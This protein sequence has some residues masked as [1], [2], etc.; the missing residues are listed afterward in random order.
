MLRKLAQFFASAP[1][2]PNGIPAGIQ[3]H[4]DAGTGRDAA[5]QFFSRNMGI[6]PLVGGQT[7]AGGPVDILYAGLPGTVYLP[8][9]NAV[10]FDTVKN[11]TFWNHHRGA[12]E[13]AF[14]QIVMADFHHGEP[15]D[16]PARGTA[17]NGSSF[18]I[19]DNG[20]MVTPGNFSFRGIKITGG[21]GAG[22]LRQ[23]NNHVILNANGHAQ[24]TVGQPWTTIPDATS[25]YMIFDTSSGEGHASFRYDGAFLNGKNLA[26][27]LGTWGLGPN[28]ETGTF[29]TQ[30]Q[31]FD[32]EIGHLLSLMH[33]GVDHILYKA[34]Y[35]SVMNYAYQFCP[36]GQSGK[37][38]NGAALTGAAACPVEGYSGVADAI[39]NNWRNV[40]LRF[41][42]NFATFGHAFGASAPIPASPFTSLPAVNLRE[43]AVRFGA[44]DEQ[45][46]T[47]T[48][49][50]PLRRSNLRARERDLRVV[51]RDR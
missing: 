24:F 31:S 37:D 9:V 46:P 12:R 4:V 41:P 28:N 27:T 20:G 42:I 16:N 45:A 25:T 47:T 3:L 11:T 6:G 35:V 50:S 2:L 17:T 13:F 51:Q 40:D 22:Q 15:N 38:A 34:N 8:G 19:E 1:A 26:V 18:T 30:F 14:M 44:L 48:I 29:V 21:T 36:P 5:Q 33:G 23:I 39:S 43:L 49:A 32:H 10:S 7:V